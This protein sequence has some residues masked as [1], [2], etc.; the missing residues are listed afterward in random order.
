MLQDGDSETIERMLLFCYIDDYDDG[1]D[2]KA[3]EKSQDPGIETLHLEEL[4]EPV[5][6]RK[7]E[8]WQILTNNILVYSIADKY[9]IDALKA[10]AKKKFKSLMEKDTLPTNFSIVARDVFN[11]TP[12]SDMGLR[13]LVVDKALDH[14]NSL[15]GDS[16]FIE[17][18]GEEAQL[19]CDLL[20][21]EHREHKELAKLMSSLASQH[22]H[23]VDSLEQKISSLELSNGTLHKTVINRHGALEKHS[24]CRHCDAEFGCVFWLGEDCLRCARCKTKH[25]TFDV[26]RN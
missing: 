8:D 26:P 9:G 6:S 20:L 19:S 21:A 1:R 23:K 5:A 7:P 24:K 18:L 17:L 14:L 22:E 3:E 12:A 16:A 4:D 15:T 2:T 10:L 13:D 25:W 11:S